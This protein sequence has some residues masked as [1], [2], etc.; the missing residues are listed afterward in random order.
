MGQRMI[1][2]G[3]G[4]KLLGMGFAASSA[5]PPFP[6]H[7]GEGDIVCLA[8]SCPTHRIHPPLDGE[9]QGGSGRGGGKPRL[10]CLAS[11]NPQPHIELTNRLPL[12]D[13]GAGFTAVAVHG[14]NQL[15]E[16]GKDF[17]AADVADQGH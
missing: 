5:P 4:G 10:E 9:G 14:G 17:L 16:A 15:V 2:G 11:D 3:F 7:K 6:P 8:A 13:Q 1:L 12:G